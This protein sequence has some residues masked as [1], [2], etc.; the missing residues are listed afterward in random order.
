MLSWSAFVLSISNY[1]F[2]APSTLLWTEH[3]A[4]SVLRHLAPMHF[5]PRTAGQRQGTGAAC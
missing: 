5:N 2:S 1:A 3:V 4:V